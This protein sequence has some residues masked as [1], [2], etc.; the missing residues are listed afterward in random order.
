MLRTYGYSYGGSMG[1]QLLI[2]LCF[3]FLYN[4]NAVQSV[5]KKKGTLD[6]KDIEGDGSDDFENGIF[7]CF[8]DM[9]VCIHG[10][11]CPLV[12]MAHTNAVA[13]IMDF[14][15]TILIYFCCA[16]F[17]GGIGPCCLTVVWRRHLKEIMQIEDHCFNDL[18]VTCLCPNLAICQQGTAVDRAMGYEVT[19][20]CNVD[21]K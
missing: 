21:F 17:T 5:I 19:G 10:L 12:R 20:C 9:W 6:D 18:F 3:A 15:Q 8:D 7:G 4:K 2:G 1:F 11:C 14:W 16:L 13:G